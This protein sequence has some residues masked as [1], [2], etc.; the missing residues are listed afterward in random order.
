MFKS[1]LVLLPLFFA[2]LTLAQES[3]WVVVSPDE[4]SFTVLMPDEPQVKTES[5]NLQGQ[6]LNAFIYDSQE[7]MAM[8]S[9]NCSDFPMAS[10]INTKD[11]AIQMLRA[12]ANSQHRGVAPENLEN[13]ELNGFVGISYQERLGGD[14]IIYNQIYLVE[15]KLYQLSVGD[16]DG[17]SQEGAEKFFGSFSVD[18]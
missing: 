12:N 4:C 8:Y 10:V 1:I 16:L 7:G 14:A 13:I 9:L 6:V 17:T 3:E 5:M 11:D 2:N 15:D 18:K